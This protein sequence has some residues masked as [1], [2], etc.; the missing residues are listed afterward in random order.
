MKKITIFALLSVIVA[1]SVSCKSN[2][3]PKEDIGVDQESLKAIDEMLDHDAGRETN[4]SK[5]DSLVAQAYRDDK[6]T[7]TIDDLGK[8]DTT[9]TS[10]AKNL[11]LD[12]NHNKLAVVFGMRAK[13]KMG[14]AIAQEEG[15]QPIRLPQT[16]DLENGNGVFSNGSVSISSDGPIITVTRNGK[17]VTYKRIM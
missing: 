1:F 8:K 14:L 10:M 16:K 4:M 17:T 11:Y 2:D 7:I 15:G 12:E 9:Y 5:S 3:K 13:G 6:T